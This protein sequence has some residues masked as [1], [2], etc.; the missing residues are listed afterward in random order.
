MRIREEERKT[1]NTALEQMQ[2]KMLPKVITLTRVPQDSP[3]MP[4]VKL[5]LYLSIGGS[6]VSGTGPAIRCRPDKS[7]P[8]FEKHLEVDRYGFE[9]DTIF[10]EICVYP[11]RNDYQLLN[12][13]M[14]VGGRIRLLFNYLDGRITIV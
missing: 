1:I 3:L 10:L 8:A 12:M 6:R 7:Y 13:L 14:E 11:T 5:Q 4:E 9:T 2:F